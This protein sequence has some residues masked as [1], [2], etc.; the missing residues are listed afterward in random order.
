MKKPGLPDVRRAVHLG[1]RPALAPRV[2]LRDDR[3]RGC[4][5]VL[6]PERVLLPDPIASSV[7]ARCD[8]ARSV[9]A[10]A[11]DLA[12]EHRERP[13]VV[14]RDVVRLLQRL[15]DDGWIRT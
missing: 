11:V 6:G 15:S 1:S 2:R 3:A 13:E 12:A 10:I 8:G 5:V 9:Q 7:L 4:K 14:E